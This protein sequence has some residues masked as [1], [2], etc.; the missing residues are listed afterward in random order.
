MDAGIKCQH[1][2]SCRGIYLQRSKSSSAQN[3]YEPG[4]GEG[5]G[6]EE[7]EGR[8][9]GCLETQTEDPGEEEKHYPGPA[10]PARICTTLG[11][12]N[13]SS[14]PGFLRVVFPATLPGECCPWSLRY[15]CAIRNRCPCRAF[16]GPLRWITL[17]R[18]QPTLL[19][20][21]ASTIAIPI[22]TTGT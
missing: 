8:G 18:R 2:P 19:Y 6:G 14:L 17:C 7:R 22:L 4:P 16:V 1:Q 5:R 15:S 20:L 9:R 12:N 10:V 13:V 21:V 11:R 3:V